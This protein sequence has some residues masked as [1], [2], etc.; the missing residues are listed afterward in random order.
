MGISSRGKCFFSRAK[1]LSNSEC[2]TK[3]LE[4]E[5]KDLKFF[6]EGKAPPY[7]RLC[8]L[9]PF[10]IQATSPSSSRMNWAIVYRFASPVPVMWSFS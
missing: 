3:S 7:L 5:R 10:L 6:G 8:S 2:F 9:M 1:P 4:F